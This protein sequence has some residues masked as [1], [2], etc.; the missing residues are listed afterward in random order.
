MILF[1]EN[2]RTDGRT[3]RSYFIG[4]LEKMSKIVSYHENKQKIEEL[5]EMAK[6]I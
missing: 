2:V 1:Q 6:V 4:P 5:Q 3:E